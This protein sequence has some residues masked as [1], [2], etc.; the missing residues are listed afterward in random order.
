MSGGAED[1]PDSA[2]MTAVRN[3]DD[4]AFGKLVEKHQR[5]LMNF[6]ARMGVN[7][8]DAEELTQLTFIKLY[9]HRGT[10]RPSAKFTTWLYLL[11]R[12]TRVDEVR[13]AARRELARKAA[14]LERD[15][16]GANAC[17]P[18]QFGLRDDLQAALGKLDEDH[19]AVVVLG[20][21]QELPYQ[22]V[23]QILGIPTGTVKSRMHNALKKLRAILEE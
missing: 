2:L 12:Q 4:G 20:M 16:M 13:S 10:Y 14:E 7:I 1:D 11:A 17:E 18:P 3:G 21:V 6:F 23:G 22:E 15:I 5:P 9:R 19:R 8:T